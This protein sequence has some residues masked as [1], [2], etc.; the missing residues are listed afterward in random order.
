MQKSLAYHSGV[1][2]EAWIFAK[3]KASRAGQRHIDDTVNPPGPRG[4]DDDAVGKKYRLGNRVRY[5]DHRFPGF[6][7]QLLKVERELVPRNCIQ[8]TKWLVH[9]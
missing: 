3:S 1:F 8:R 5:K 7:P 4:H 9:Q 2:K 6:G